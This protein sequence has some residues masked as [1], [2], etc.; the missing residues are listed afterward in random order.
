MHKSYRHAKFECHR[1][2]IVRD[3]NITVQAKNSC[4]VSDA[5]ATLSEGQ[6]HQTEKRRY[7]PLVGLSSQRNLKSV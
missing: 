3:I 4:Q 2:E 5:V 6:G 1:L 7:I